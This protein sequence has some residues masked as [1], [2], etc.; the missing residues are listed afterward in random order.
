MNGYEFLPKTPELVEQRRIALDW[1]ANLAQTSQLTVHLVILICELV[2][3]RK[4]TKKS[5]QRGDAAVLARNLKFTLST[6]VV[7]GYG[8]YGQWVFGI[9]WTAWLGF[10]CIT[11]TAPDYLHLTKRFGLVAASQLP[12]HYLL[13]ATPLQLALRSSSYRPNMSL[14]KVTGKI[15]IAFF[16]VHMSL[17]SICFVQMGI[18]WKSVQQPN[19]VVALI[20]AGILFIIGS[21][22]TQF[23]RRRYYSW[24]YMLHVIGSTLVLPLLFFHVNHIRIYLFESAAVLIINAVLRSRNW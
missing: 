5:R 6:E 23:F 1:Y 14:H 7:K 15:I 2:Q 18:F 16:A 9:A 17:Y 11:E 19:I 3:V 13:A 12:I 22:A 21:T 20:S 10:L 24:F 4:F 8:T